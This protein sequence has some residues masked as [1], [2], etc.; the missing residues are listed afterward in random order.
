METKRFIGSDLHRLYDRVRREF[1]ADASI[2]GT[3]TLMREGAEPLIELTAGPPGYASDGLGFELERT[4]VDG[5]LE[6]LETIERPL[7]F[8]D[9]EDY[10]T[11]GLS[12]GHEPSGAAAGRYGTAADAEDAEQL[13]PSWLEGYVDAPLPEAEEWPDHTLEVARTAVR[14]QPSEEAPA[15]VL[16]HPHAM[17]G[18]VPGIVE[19][20]VHRT[21]SAAQIVQQSLSDAGFDPETVRVIASGIEGVVSPAEAVAAQLVG[22]DV[23]MP[24]AGRPAL[25]TVEGPEG[26]GKT[27]ALMRMALEFSDG[28]Q[29]LAL[30]AADR[31]HVG[32]TSQVQAYAEALGVAALVAETSD[33]VEQAFTEDPY[34]RWLLADLAAGPWAPSMIAPEHCYRYLAIPCHWQASAVGKLLAGYDLAAF[35][36]AILTC[37]DIA[38]DLTPILSLLMESQLGVAFLSSERDVTT[39][40]RPATIS[41]LASGIFLTPTRETTDGRLVAFA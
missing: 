10:V 5:V 27:T 39:G 37:T 22:R 29:S 38:T 19:L 40:M 16:A 3:R 13:V 23:R 18:G 31:T 21:A 14:H 9:I 11:R 28:G 35:R 30:I 41:S 20:A 2:V 15:A 8:G 34:G 17:R 32:A 36:G 33:G 26:S 24:M 1:G 12:D 4:M 6:R 25:I 7:T